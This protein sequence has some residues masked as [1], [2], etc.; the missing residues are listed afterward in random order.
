[1]ASRAKIEKK[2]KKTLNDLWPDVKM[3]SQNFP[4]I[5]LYQ[6]WQNGSALLKKWSPELKK[7]TFKRHLRGQWI[8]K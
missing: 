1:M 6:N 4:L 8:S 5:P 7:I 3:I 2:K